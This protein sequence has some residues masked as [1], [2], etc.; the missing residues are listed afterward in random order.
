MSLRWLLSKVPQWQWQ[1]QIS[2]GRDEVSKIR[3]RGGDAKGEKL[4]QNTQ[5]KR[6]CRDNSLDA[7]EGWMSR[8]RTDAL[9]SRTTRTKAGELRAGGS[10]AGLI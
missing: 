3:I 8:R 2:V 1:W 5:L 7:E 10:R 9:T 4:A 6:M